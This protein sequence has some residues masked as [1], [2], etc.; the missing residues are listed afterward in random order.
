[1]LPKQ[2]FYLPNVS[3]SFII[4][5]VLK[6]TFSFTKCVVICL[7]EL[8]HRSPQQF[9]HVWANHQCLKEINKHISTIVKY[10][11]SWRH[12]KVLRLSQGNVKECVSWCVYSC[13]KTTGYCILFL[14]W[15]A[16]FPP[17]SRYGRSLMPTL[18]DLE[19]TLRIEHLIFQTPVI[20]YQFT[21]AVKMISM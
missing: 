3:L 15:G 19:Q 6:T 1:M 9:H 14:L 13:G 7:S 12:Q 5:Q 4:K 18:I 21:F 10:V 11:A 20:T 2:H 17:N 16:A 8:D